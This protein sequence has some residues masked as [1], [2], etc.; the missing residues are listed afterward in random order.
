MIF[1]SEAN[2]GSSG[3][4][5]ADS[6]VVAS[7]SLKRSN[8]EKEGDD[9]R[10]S[11]TKRPNLR[12]DSENSSDTASTVR[13]LI[14]NASAGSVIGKGGSTISEFQ[15]QSGAR[16]QLSRNREFFP[17]TTERVILLSGSVSAILTA[18]H[19][20][21]SKISTEDSGGSP[22]DTNKTS[23]V[24]L[25]VP[26][27]VCGGI[28]G[29]GG[30]TI[31][32]FVEDS[33]ANIK[34]SSQ[35]QALPGV[36]DRVVTITG[37]LDQQLRAV[38]LIVTKMSEDPNYLLYA[39]MP[40][41]YPVPDYYV[42]ARDPYVPVRDPY[43]AGRDPYVADY[44]LPVQ[45]YNSGAAVPG[46]GGHLAAASSP[47]TPI[48]AMPGGAYAAARSKG[49]PGAPMIAGP[50]IQTHPPITTVTVAVPD[51][52]VGAI[53]GRSGKTINEIQQMSAV[54][55]KISE[56]GDFV[57]GTNNR[58]VT[59]TGSA[60]AVQFAQYLITTKVQNSAAEANSYRRGGE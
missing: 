46:Y 33:G 29:K 40:I 37:T 7:D 38:A 44:R 50:V 36:T 24:R 41:S 11:P 28:I 59:I 48:Q 39:N 27:A 58:K 8:M 5:A 4:G 10:G 19:L 22:P 13:F 15:I 55:I 14:S 1:G 47:Y 34:L 2:G 57:Q 54:R 17:G 43:I 18:L 52:H 23:Q 56:R 49:R 16:I 25:I 60:E 45:V 51:E 21:L 31:R 6:N 42:P 20:I 9:D 3:K 53:V 26:N 35:D 30:A 32:S 12:A